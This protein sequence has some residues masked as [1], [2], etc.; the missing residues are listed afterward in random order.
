M[1]RLIYRRIDIQTCRLIHDLQTYRH[2]VQKYR[3]TVGTSRHV[4]LQ[5]QTYRY[6][7][8]QTYIYLYTFTYYAKQEL[9][10]V[11][12]WRL[13]LLGCWIPWMYL[14]KI[15]LQFVIYF[16]TKNHEKRLMNGSHTT[17]E[18]TDP[19]TVQCLVM[20]AFAT[21]VEYSALSFFLMLCKKQS[22]H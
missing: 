10:N 21:T 9:M 20:K 15:N 6:V 4:D 13:K 17:T 14:V 1:H 5:T 3:H 11:V 22:A 19:I 8:I 18:N 12:V 2:T 16:Q 7:D